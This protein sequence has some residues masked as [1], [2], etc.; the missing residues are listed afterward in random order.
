MPGSLRNLVVALLVLVLPAQTFAAALMSLCAAVH[1]PAHETAR[2]HDSAARTAQAA[3]GADAHG[4]HHAA[5][6]GGPE[7]GAMDTASPPEA[8]VPAGH[9]SATAAHH[10]GKSP[11][12]TCAVC[13]A[14]CHGWF[15]PA[16]LAA[17][18]PGRI[19]PAYPSARDARPPGVL[20]DRLERPPR[21]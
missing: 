18:L 7:H 17:R 10:D 14:C 5:L 8:P 19:E 16:E 13:A 20:P 6:P 11:A 1:G 4:G 15:A 12:D 3:H 2:L 9:V 21:L